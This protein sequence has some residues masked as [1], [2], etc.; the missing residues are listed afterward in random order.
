MYTDDN[1]RRWHG[2]HAFNQ[3]AI[4]MN[5]PDRVGVYQILYTGGTAQQVA[6]IGIATGD[7]I[8]GRL[9]K[10]ASGTGNR[11]LA[12]LGDPTKFAFVY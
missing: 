12:R 10:H 7:T 3:S 4:R 6:Y 2:P 5:A 1:G 11:H 9:L 8:R